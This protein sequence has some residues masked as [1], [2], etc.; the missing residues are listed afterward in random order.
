MAHRSQESSK[1][2]RTNLNVDT[3]LNKLAQNEAAMEMLKMNQTA[4]AINTSNDAQ[5]YEEKKMIKDVLINLRLYKFSPAKMTHRNSIK[6]MFYGKSETY[7]KEKFFYDLFGYSDDNYKINLE[8][9]QHLFDIFDDSSSTKYFEIALE[10]IYLHF[11]ELKSFKFSSVE[12]ERLIEQALKI[13][14]G[15]YKIE[16]L[17]ILLVFSKFLDRS[18]YQYLKKLILAEINRI[19]FFYSSHAHYYMCRA[20]YKEMIRDCNIEFFNLLFLLHENFVIQFKTDYKK[21]VEKHKHF[22]GEYWNYAIQR[23]GQLLY[24]MADLQNLVDSKEFLLLKTKDSGLKLNLM[25][26][27]RRIW[28]FQALLNKNQLIIDE[29]LLYVSLRCPSK[30]IKNDFNFNL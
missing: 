7:R 5:E 22:F 16:V 1:L 8:L 19:S 13:K 30:I 9:F 11:S 2:L 6:N 23:N 21:F 15:E 28:E 25:T 17:K 18:A 14:N 4:I 26:T 20:S 24:L 3:N 27:F 10:A 29:K 12:L